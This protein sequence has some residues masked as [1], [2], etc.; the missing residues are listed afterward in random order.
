MRKSLLPL[1]SALRPVERRMLGTC[2]AV[3]I[4]LVA[5]TG[6]HAVFGVGGNAVETPIRDWLTS[7]VYILVGVIVCWRAVRT[8]ESRASWML[9]AFGISIYGL[10]N[11][12]WA[13]WIEHL[14]NP[15]IPS[16][17]DGMWLTLY[18][19]CYL[20]I[21]GL[22]RLR[23]RRVPARMWLDGIV[24][25]L[26]IAAIGAAIVVR[27]V[28]ATVSGGTAAVITE[29][30]YPLCDLLLA[31]L[32][33]GVLALRGWRL[34]RMW[35][36]LGI[37]F[38][39]LTV[40]DCMYALQVAGGAAAP[41]AL[42]NM[43]YDIGVMLLAL[44]AW[45]PGAAIETDTVPSSAVLAIPA[46]FTVSALGLLIYDHFSRLDPIA[47]TLAM[48]TML[49]AFAR[50]ALTFRDVRALAETRRQ[51]MTDD[52]TLMPNRRHFL[53]CVRDGIIASGATGERVALLIVD[54]DHFKELNDT[55]GH[56]AGDQLLRQVGE[57]LRAVLRASDTAARLGGDEFG[58]L[59]SDSSSGTSAE[60]V[61][62]KILKTIAQPF[63]IKNVGLR[64]TASIGI[65]IYP[66]HAEDDEQLMQHADVAMYE[67]KAAQSGYAC[68][69]RERDKH[70]LERLTL[71]GELSHALEAGE[72]EAHFQP[73][74][75]AG[76]RK[77]VGVEALVRWQHPT[78]GL[79]SPAEFVTVAE[80]AGLGRALTRRM[81]D[82]ALTQVRIWREEGFDLHVAVNTTVADLQ[83]TQ[84]P[85][86][87]A[88]TLEAHGLPPEALVLEVTE[89]M[90]LA[91]PVRVGDVL[92]QLGELGLGLSLDD[93][94]TG[95]SSLT[96]LKSLP[97]GEV[98]IDRSFVGRMTTDPVDAA[99]VQATIQLAHSIGIRVVAEGIEDQVTWSSLVANRCELV[100][101]Y[102]LSRPLPA[103]DLDTL[104]RAQPQPEGELEELELPGAGAVELLDGANGGSENG[105]TQGAPASNGQGG[106]G[107][108][109]DERSEDGP[110]ER[111]RFN[112]GRGGRAQVESPP[113]ALRDLAAL[114]R[115][116]PMMDAVIEELDGRMIRVGSQWL[117]D[118][119]SC[120]YLGF[121]LD[122]EIIEAVPAYLDAWG[123]HPSW[124][125]LLGSPALYEQIEQR[126][127]ALL[128]SADS[129]VLPTITH[130][131]LSTI[132]ALAESGTILL[133]ARAHK[134]IYDGC[135]MARARGAAVKR[136][137]FED[138]QH[139]EELLRGAP[140]GARLVCM[141]GV[142]SMT[143]NPPDIRAFAKVAREHGA[144]LYVDDA[145][146][147]GVIGERG[148]AERCPYGMRG[149]SIVRYYGE[150]YENLI[151]VGGFSK[152]YSS[153]LAF[154]ACPTEMKEM[155]K[156]AAA[157]YLYSGPS[158]VA[159]LATTLA[160]FD[161][162]ERRGEELRER[163]WAH[164]GRVLECLAH[165]G[166]ATPNRSGMPIVE[167][168]LRDHGRIAEVGQLLFDRGV[169]VTLAAYPLVPR[170]EVG[171]RVQVTAANTDAEVDAL[172]AVLEELAGLGELRS[173]EQASAPPVEQASLPS[174]EQASAPQRES[175]A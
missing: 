34:D 96:H 116:H 104:L 60:L 49:F 47:L 129:L 63:P 174:V 107:Q 131:H 42:T 62:E 158:P 124:S 137:R 118:F 115:S 97:V 108:A 125:R 130:I 65:A 152:S 57:R 117:A 3:L 26:G 89:N 19:C 90:V 167:V 10:G 172:I 30:A 70:S 66:E 71:A 77:I 43:T 103:I 138:P 94:G 99:I 101:G 160:G 123:T 157:P 5:A 136:F 127:T 153:L 175:V 110:G 55:L 134:T 168:P 31:A 169:Y 161:V 88:A 6:L 24:A 35:A 102:A 139:L 155:L 74:A 80:Q 150:S 91:D 44:A 112:G 82:L 15:P 69:A 100:Q 11:V 93:F 1:D 54:L 85:A 140:G 39:A 95:F 86:E 166:V 143:G 146:G 12:L 59:L 159:S 36:M 111:A 76:S 135:Q 170:D 87:V 144:L 17:C 142:N 78:R 28:L 120:N 156:V 41:S 114:T 105:A 147:F 81:L 165:L 141:D 29:M 61:A 32:V 64:V 148:P 51:A 75:D 145:H 37:G 132:P 133:D 52:L 173:I 53:R 68:Y 16:I 164:T 22:A 119:A 9:F 18:P 79:I 83:D 113:A 45:Q 48:L 4:A 2:T 151:L 58:V 8:T 14:P 128:G 40:A 50:V 73:K 7:A 121:D 98:K 84:F 25:G 163:V 92:A 122:R 106:Y 38:I 33:V 27:P 149:N 56:D 23:E 162:N 46:A 171:F 13:A 126:L 72:I 154:I 21:V 20:G 67:A 109:E